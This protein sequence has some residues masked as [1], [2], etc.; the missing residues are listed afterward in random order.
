MTESE[1][2]EARH[3][4]EASQGADGAIAAGGAVLAGRLLAAQRVISALDVDADV[5]TRLQPRLMAICT[6]LKV[7]G[8]S[9][10]RCCGR[11]D[12]LMADAERERGDNATAPGNPWKPGYFCARPGDRHLLLLNCTQFR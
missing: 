5:R 7:P 3:P 9:K 6:A 10:A 1:P 11:L 8:A 12:R 2:D 4:D